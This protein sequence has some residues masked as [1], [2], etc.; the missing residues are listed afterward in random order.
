MGRWRRWARSWLRSSPARLPSTRQNETPGRRQPGG[1]LFTTAA[2][3]GRLGLQTTGL[4]ATCR[5]RMAQV[6]TAIAH[7]L[8]PATD[9]LLQCKVENG[10][11]EIRRVRVTS[12]VEG[13]SAQAIET[14]EIKSGKFHEFDQLP[15]FFP[16]RLTQMN[17]LTR[18]TLHVRVDD[19][20]GKVEL[21]RTQA[22][23]LL[24]RT[25]APLAV[26]DPMTGEWRDL[27]RYLGAFVTPNEPELEKVLRDAVD[28]AP[29][30]QFV[31]YQAG[32]G[33]RR[34]AGEG[35][36]RRLAEESSCDT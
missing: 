7:L 6:P 3:S 24:P 21:H 23:W 13:Y 10:S 9:P 25:T 1:L 19:L 31:S 22:I 33:R 4:E 30:H 20:D 34:P 27:T 15:T 35:A 17:E 29:D 32:S 18:A 5:L 28:L 2:E 14:F 12:F 36:L 26:K 11:T 8:D 16:D